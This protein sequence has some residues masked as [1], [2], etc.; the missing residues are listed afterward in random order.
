MLPGAVGLDTSFVVHTLIESQSLHAPC[1]AFL[2]RLV[3]EEVRLVVSELR[4]VELAEAVFRIAL[5]ERWGRA[6]RRHRTDGRARRRAQRILADV[7][8][9]Y[10]LFLGAASETPIPL[11]RVTRS[12]ATLMTDHGIASYDAVHAA[13]AVA[14]GAEAIVTT[15]IGFGLLPTSLLAIYTDRSRLTACRAMRPTR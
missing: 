14:A 9:R 2:E 15:D 7:Q 11:A 10:E 8:S 12:A 4:D 6:W 1:S 13:T 3:V 5:T